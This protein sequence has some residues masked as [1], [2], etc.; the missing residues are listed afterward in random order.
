VIHKTRINAWNLAG[1]ALLLALPCMWGVSYLHQDSILW[2]RG[3]HRSLAIGSSN[4][5]IG[6][7]V[8]PFAFST[9]SLPA[10]HYFAG[11]LSTLEHWSE[12]IDDPSTAIH[13]WFVCRWQIYPLINRGKGTSFL[14]LYPIG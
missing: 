7:M 13:E 5:R 8:I 11:D 4:G 9:D 14:Y 6:V 12:L 2:L 3:G 10:W 1:W